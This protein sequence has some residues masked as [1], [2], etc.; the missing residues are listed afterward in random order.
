M[1]AMAQEHNASIVQP[2]PVIPFNPQASDRTS[3]GPSFAPASEHQ[4]WQP[5]LQTAVPFGPAPF[6]EV[7]TNLI[8]NPNL[9]SSHV[10]RAEIWWDSATEY[11]D[12]GRDWPSEERMSPSE[13]KS[14]SHMRAECR[15]WPVQVP[16][17]PWRWER[18]WVRKMIP[19]NPRLDRALVQSCHVL[20]RG[21]RREARLKG[22]GETVEEVYSSSNVDQGEQDEQI[23]MIYVPHAS[24][25]EEVPFYHPPVSA[26][27][28]VH[29]WDAEANKGRL[30][31]WYRMFETKEQGGTD[32]TIL[33]VQA[34]LSDGQPVDPSPILSSRLIRTA[35]HLLQIIYKHGKGKLTNYQKRVH[36]DRVISQDV[37]QDKYTE[38]KMKYARSLIEKWV[39]DTPAEKHVFEDLGIA[40]FCICLWNKMG[41]GSSE[42]GQKQRDTGAR[43]FP[44]FIDV[45]CGNGVLVNILIQEGWQ[46]TGFDAR[47]RKSWATFSEDVQDCL[48][49]ELLVPKIF[50]SGGPTLNGDDHGSDRVTSEQ[51]AS[52]YN[53]GIFHPGTFIISNHADELTAWTP[54][55]AYLNGSSFIA[56][57]CCSHDLSGARTRFTVKK[58][59][60]QEDNETAAQSSIGDAGIRSD[61]PSHGDLKALRTDD[62]DG[63]AHDLASP[64]ISDAKESTTKQT[65]K[66]PSAYA[67]LTS[68]VTS[69]TL[70]LGFKAE[71][72]MLR[73]P[74]TRNAA[75][76]GYFQSTGNDD[77]GA[78]ARTSEEMRQR[79]LDEI[80]SIV[81][82]ELKEDVASVG[83]KWIQRAEKIQMTKGQCH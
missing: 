46:G 11:G 68:Y 1:K 81:R 78:L 18:T 62:S 29:S 17:G 43:E 42:D 53:N 67:A 6:R 75:V 8:R 77:P 12:D 48:R 57:P 71:K 70:E 56:I 40:A 82:R 61:Q 39:E 2:T 44:G 28:F 66:Q 22:G 83:R 19:R 15:P 27:A 36:H 5:T 55:L 37:F 50:L 33:E 45:A 49:E 4:Q 35:N 69:L 13:S 54:L 59:R 23:V 25:P 34:S 74:S 58:P 24:S 20:R 51:Q 31:V 63:K 14:L 47:G 64:P 79:K 30:E 3:T 60:Q 26:V 80:A 7:M 52:R 32:S 38:L 41:Y 10:F 73:I 76:I 9:T 65:W 16:E 21:G 72:E